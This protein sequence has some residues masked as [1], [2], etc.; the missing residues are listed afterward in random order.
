MFEWDLKK[1]VI[2]GILACG[3]V[4]GGIYFSK[5]YQPSYKT[6]EIYSSALDDFVNGDYQNAYYLFSKITIF[7]PLKPVAVYHRAE[8]ARML[9]DDKSE[10]RQYEIL[11]NNYPKHQLSIR[12]RYLAAQKL[13]KDKP[14]VAKKYFEYIIHN[15]PDTDYAIASEYY[16]GCTKS[17]EVIYWQIDSANRIRTG[18]IM[19]YDPTTGGR[20]K[21]TSG[22]KRA[23]EE[24]KA[25]EKERGKGKAGKKNRTDCQITKAP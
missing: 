13:I 16:L 2:A 11:F 12:S 22:A 18:K 3:I 14:K 9:N 17:G 15:A 24:G 8:C 21:K 19:Q 25:R 10:I 23:E 6:D 4:S 5:I 7:S 20:L 1:R